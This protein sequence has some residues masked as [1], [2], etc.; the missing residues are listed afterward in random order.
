M[1]GPFATFG[2]SSVQPAQVSLNQITI[3]ASVDLVWPSLSTDSDDTVARIMEVTASVGSLT[4]DMPPANEVGTGQDVLFRNMGSNTFTVRDYDGN[5]IASIAAGISKYIYITDNSTEA[6]SWAVITFGTGTSAADASALA[7]YGLIAIGATLNQ[8]HEVIETSSNVTIDLTYLATTV[9][10]TSGSLTCTLPTSA[11]MDDDFF[12][13]ARN[14]GNGTIAVTPGG[15]DTI[16][17]AVS[18]N[19][20]PGDSCFIFSAGSSNAWYTSGLGRAVSFAFTQLV[21]SVAGNSNVTLSSTEAANKVMTFTGILTG[22]ISVIVPNTVSVYYVYNNTTGAFTLTVK[23]AAGTGKQI[24]Q[25]TRDIVVCDATNVAGAITN[26][27]GITAYSTGSAG[28]PSITWVGDTDTGFYS[29]GDGQTAFSSN[30]AQTL[31]MSGAGITVTGAIVTTG[32]VGIGNA[33]SATTGLLVAPNATLTGVNQYQIFA[34]GTA[35]SGC[36]S[37]FNGVLVQSSTAAAAYTCAAMYGMRVN[38]A[39]LGAGS[40]ITA[41]H[42][43]RIND[44]TVGATNIGISSA[45]SAG[46]NKYNLY[47]D[48]TAANY[49]AG[50]TGIGIA[51]A[52]TAAL[53]VSGAGL[54]STDQVA[55]NLGITGSSGAT[56][57]VTG[58]LVA[59]GTAAAAFVC[60]SLYGMHVINASKGAGSTIT[61]QYGILID[62]LT[63]G[64]NNYAFSSAV[65]AGANKYNLLINGTA[66]NYL[67]GNLGVGATPSAT[68][69]LYISTA[70]A[71]AFSSLHF[72]THASNP[73][74]VYVFYPNVTPNDTAHEFL[75]CQDSTGLKASLRSNGG[76]AN[77]QAN[78]ANLSDIRVKPVF[79]DYNDEM[80]DDLEGRFMSLRR[81]RF[82]YADQ[83]HDDWNYGKSAQSVL[84]NIPELADVWNPE[85]PKEEQ[86]LCE[87][88]HDITQIGEALLVRALKRIK[89]LEYKMSLL[90]AA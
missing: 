14:S 81:G 52:T 43:I 45:V 3:A 25:G 76:L 23:T 22:N 46:A 5:T 54:T 85:A 48:G 74:G 42:G 11:S 31:L 88:S 56:A 33:I 10:W 83:T 61:T 30:G 41:L 34:S 51:P 7:G 89:D 86:L 59:G 60:S 13:I 82:K 71:G 28:A 12:F 17:G 73:A 57:S 21:K 90:K 29:P 63:V 19:L 58:V 8:A 27:A 26:T 47:M 44:Q 6:G 9:V 35:S 4:V 79:E 2:G 75:Y 70:T 16:D 24:A 18:L 62:D 72:H 68:S 39:T 37:S 49:L 87:Y 20:A 50:N 65:S 38:N 80:L 67:A 53:L 1:T 77:V 55:V 36:T 64:T 15:A 78:N 84:E 32:N 66:Q 40:A 69:A